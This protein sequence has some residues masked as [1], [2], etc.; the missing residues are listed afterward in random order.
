MKRKFWS[1]SG[2]LSLT[3]RDCW[4]QRRIKS[5][6]TSE[7]FNAIALYEASV[8]FDKHQPQVY[9]DYRS[10]LSEEEIEKIWNNGYEGLN[11]VE[12]ELM[13]L[14]WDYAEDL[15]QAHLK[16]NFIDELTH[17]YFKTDFLAAMR[18]EYSDEIEEDD[19]IVEFLLEELKD[20]IEEE[21]KAQL[22]DHIWVD[23]DF[24]Q[25]YRNTS[26]Q[27]VEL[28]FSLSDYIPSE[29]LRLDEWY[30]DEICAYSGELDIEELAEL[31]EKVKNQEG[32]LEVGIDTV[33][34]GWKKHL[35]FNGVV[36]IPLGNESMSVS[37]YSHLDSDGLYSFEVVDKYEIEPEGKFFVAEGKDALIGMTVSPL[38]QLLDRIHDTLSAMTPAGEIDPDAAYVPFVMESDDGKRF[39]VAEY[40]ENTNSALCFIAGEWVNIGLELGA[41]N[42]IVED[43]GA[44]IKMTPGGHIAPDGSMVTAGTFTLLAA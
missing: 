2:T 37:R 27:Q 31:A 44:G 43:F 22:N 3:T 24:A 39:A 8:Y 4:M 42:E 14:N 17:A 21:A 15:R 38:M 9:W 30:E 26:S 10:S 25:L 6:L 34:I 35:D 12:N 11:E 29:T 41:L 28:S 7:M 13:D 33:E 32:F 18:E 1:T 5:F 20:E 40:E 23:Y 16:E 36:Y 19:S